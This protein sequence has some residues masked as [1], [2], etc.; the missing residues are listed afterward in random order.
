[1]ASFSSWWGGGD[2]RADFGA[3]AVSVKD[4]GPAEARVA[5]RLGAGE[6]LADAAEALGITRETGR[7]LLKRVFAKADVHRQAQLVA[8][9]ARMSRRP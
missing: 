4:G 2:R 6:S 9:I 5:L 1:M 7:A 3:A 8:L